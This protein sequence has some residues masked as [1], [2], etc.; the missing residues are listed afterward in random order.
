MPDPHTLDKILL[1]LFFHLIV[2]QNII[3][4]ISI[5]YFVVQIFNIFL[6]K[7]K[8]ILYFTDSCL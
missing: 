1:E 4:M 3:H 7:P 5:S 8:I 2:H 6:E